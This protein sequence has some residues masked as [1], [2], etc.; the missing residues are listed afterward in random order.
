MTTRLVDLN[1][2]CSG[3]ERV[4]RNI[5]RVGCGPPGFRSDGYG[6]RPARRNGVALAGV[7]FGVGAARSV[8]KR[9]RGNG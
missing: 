9:Q 6:A 3:G 2:G 7:A 1:G 8:G 4:A 5:E